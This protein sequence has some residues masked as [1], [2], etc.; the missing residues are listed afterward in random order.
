MEPEAVLDALLGI[1]EE[2][3]WRVR[4]VPLQ[5]GEPGLSTRSG[6]CRL[7]GETWLLLATGDSLEERIQAVAEALRRAAPELLEGRFLPP[8]VRARV[9]GRGV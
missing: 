3:G 4:R 9:E 5:A 8:A 2:A 1:A 7:R 6:L